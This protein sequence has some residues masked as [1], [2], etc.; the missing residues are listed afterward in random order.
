MFF[1]LYVNALFFACRCFLFLMV[2]FFFEWD[3]ANAINN[4]KV[5]NFASTSI[6]ITSQQMNCVI[7][8]L[9]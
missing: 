8:H 5:S 3:I 1:L 4:L 6:S 9:S 7:S 2:M